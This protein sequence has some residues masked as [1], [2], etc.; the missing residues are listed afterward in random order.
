VTS[1]RQTKANRVNAKKSTGPRSAS[2]K[3]AS[4]KNAIRHGLLSES[5]TMSNE[6]PAEFAKHV[7]SLVEALKPVGALE[8]QLSRRI[9]ELSWRLARVRRLEVGV[10]EEGVHRHAASNARADVAKLEFNA[11]VTAERRQLD[12]EFIGSDPMHMITAGRQIRNHTLEEWSKGLQRLKAA[13]TEIRE[14]SAAPG[15]V[16]GLIRDRLS[17]LSRYE[18]TLDRGLSRALG[19]LAALQE[20]RADDPPE[21]ETIQAA[22]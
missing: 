10:L 12:L 22:I 20:K 5:A 15:A 11:D 21:D 3:A 4:A 18:T 2:G 19:D 1:E 7:E 9:A 16:Y 13:E 17:N 8:L 6:D 14:G